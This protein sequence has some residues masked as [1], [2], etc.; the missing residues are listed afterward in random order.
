MSSAYLACLFLLCRGVASSRYPSSA[1]RT[2]PRDAGNFSSSFMSNLSNL[3]NVNRHNQASSAYYNGSSYFQSSSIAL[4][5]TALPAPNNSLLWQQQTS[6]SSYTPPKIIDVMC[7]THEHNPMSF[8]DPISNFFQICVLW[9]PSCPGKQSEA[10]E[11]LRSTYSG[12]WTFGIHCFR[13]SICQCLIDGQPLP[14]AWTPYFREVLAYLRSPQCS[15]VFNEVDLTCCRGCYFD[16]TYVDIYYWPAV[17]ANTACLNIVGN[18]TNPLYY[19]A[20]TETFKG[21]TNTAT[22]WGCMSVISWYLPPWFR[23]TTYTTAVITNVNGFTFKKS[24]Y[25]PWARDGPCS[26]TNLSIST[27]TTNSSPSPALTIRARS[28]ISTNPERSNGD[29]PSSVITLDGYTL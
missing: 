8:P 14:V 18:D 21:S 26:D 11:K 17:D 7:N 19:G 4:N 27:V 12:F 9:N 10:K 22:Y 20:T 16:R 13:S 15:L 1:P 24:W 2:L 23:T 25:N 29:P 3:S 28:V 6:H 5:L